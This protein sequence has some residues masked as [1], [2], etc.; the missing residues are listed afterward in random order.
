MTGQAIADSIGTPRRVLVSGS[1]GF[2]GRRL[3][4]LLEA[5]GCSVRGLSRSPAGPGQFGW[6]PGAGWID[7]AALE[8]V[9]AIIH[10][11][12]ENIASGR[13]TKARRRRILASR[14]DGTRTLVEA[15]AKLRRRPAVF[16]CASGVN[17]YGTGPLVCDESSPRGDGFLAD[18]CEFWEAEAMAAQRLGVRTVLVRTGVVLDPSGGALARLLPV[19]RLGL[20]GPVGSGRQA[21][22]WIGLD[23]LAEIYALA[24]RDEGLAGPLN[25]VHPQVVT[26]GEFS[27]TLGKALRR[28]AIL[29]LPAWLVRL[30]FGQ[31]GRET[32]LGDL[33]VRPAVLLAR[34]HAFRCR[35]LQE[36]LEFLRQQAS[37]G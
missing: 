32:L 4:A 3:V 10:L 35:G 20:G 12:G 2:I 34:Q 36:Q 9:D 16:V 27:R 17:F 1:S 25:A 28:P 31:M 21:F 15:M 6:N 23:D 8:D 30:V 7:P 11:A 29:P 24:L 18:V 19:F 37:A 5:H 13:W 33:T 26:Q 22:P 14:V